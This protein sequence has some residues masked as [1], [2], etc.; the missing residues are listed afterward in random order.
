MACSPAP[1]VTVQP[2]SA[3][4][5]A[6]SATLVPYRNGDYEQMLEF[7]PKIANA[8]SRSPKYFGIAC[9]TLVTL[10][11]LILFSDLEGKTK[12]VFVGF[13][14]APFTLTLFQSALRADERR[15]SHNVEDGEPPRRVRG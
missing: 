14:V 3:H 5:G 6:A 8:I 12:A 4:K 10:V 1:A 13:L 7:L 2:T 9:M 11:G 15:D